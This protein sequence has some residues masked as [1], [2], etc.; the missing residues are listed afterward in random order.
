MSPFA[1]R[2]SGLAAPGQWT[3]RQNKPG[4][5]AADVAI[6]RHPT[7]GPGG[8]PDAATAA[9]FAGSIVT[10]FGSGELRH[11]QHADSPYSIASECEQL[12]CS[13]R[14]PAET[15][16]TELAAYMSSKSEIAARLERIKGLWLEL[17]HV[18]PTTPRYEALMKEIRTESSAYLALITA[19][20]DLSQTQTRNDVHPRQNGVDRREIDRRQVI[21][22]K[23]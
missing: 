4:A 3:G 22:R 23:K 11:F 12:R 5:C 17:E 9:R 21:R 7:N 16:G 8:T 10:V 6:L 15:D 2:A 1:T 19:Q 20:D 14:R 13:S 18:Q